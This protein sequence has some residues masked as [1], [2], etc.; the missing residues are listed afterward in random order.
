MQ[1]KKFFF[2]MGVVECCVVGGKWDVLAE[3]VDLTK[4]W[5]GRNANV[6]GYRS[7]GGFGCVELMY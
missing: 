4:G 2:V 7:C 3:V 6:G 5:R 1:V